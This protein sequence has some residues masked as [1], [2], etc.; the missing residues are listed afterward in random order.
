MPDYKNTKDFIKQQLRNFKEATTASKVVREAAIITAPA[1]LNRVQQNGQK[2]D[3]SQ[4]GKYGKGTIK[5]AI[6]K[7][8]S[9]GSKKRLKK[10]TNEDPYIILRQKLGLQTN[11]IDF[12]F[13]GDMFK[14]WRPVP[15]GANSW[16]VT[17]TSK[18][19]YDLANSLERRFGITF[20]LSSQEEKIALA[21]IV[22][23]AIKYL[24]Q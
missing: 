9:F 17:F 12:T 8:Q 3:G 16:G 7:A 19:Q 10:V 18:E 6:S 4:I 13:S 14:T 23:N 21:S 15:T 24:G 2:S 11:Y 22:K 20:D 5:S 1:I